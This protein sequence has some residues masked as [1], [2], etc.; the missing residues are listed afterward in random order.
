MRRSK[1][2]E[3]SQSPSLSGAPT[4]AFTHTSTA[5]A[6]DSRHWRL[7]ATDTVKESINDSSRT[8]SAAVVVF[9]CPAAI[10]VGVAS[11]S[12]SRQ[13]FLDD[14]LQHKLRAWAQLLYIQSE[15]DRLVAGHYLFYIYICI[16]ISILL[17]S[18]CS[19]V[20]ISIIFLYISISTIYY[21]II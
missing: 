9:L 16:Y 11:P 13:C 18:I 12:F 7:C 3:H 19:Y 5:V 8:R 20:S 14:L 1:G 21:L 2:Q 10:G 17:I 6:T 15:P 4:A